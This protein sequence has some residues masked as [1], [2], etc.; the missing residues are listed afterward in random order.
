[1]NSSANGNEIRTYW[2]G[3]D[4]KGLF[5]GNFFGPSFWAVVESWGGCTPA[6]EGPTYGAGYEAWSDPAKPVTAKSSPLHTIFS[7][8]Y[9][10]EKNN[11]NAGIWPENCACPLDIQGK[12]YLENTMKASTKPSWACW[13]TSVAGAGVENAGLG[14]VRTKYFDPALNAPKIYFHDAAGGSVESIYKSNFSL[15][16]LFSLTKTIAYA[17][18]I[19]VPIVGPSLSNNLR[20]TWANTA[21]ILS[22]RSTG[23]VTKNNV[24]V[25]MNWRMD[26]HANNPIEASLYSFYR[27]SAKGEDGWESRATIES[28]AINTYFV[29]GN[30]PNSS[31]SQYCCNDFIAKWYQCGE[32]GVWNTTM[33]DKTVAFI[34]MNNSAPWINIK[35]EDNYRHYEEKLGCSLFKLK[36]NLKGTGAKLD[37]SYLKILKNEVKW[38]ISRENKVHI[39]VIDIMGKLIYSNDLAPEKD[40]TIFNAKNYPNR[41]LMIVVRDG[42][43]E[44]MYKLLN[45]E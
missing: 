32:G 16:F 20:Q 10:C 44:E 42:A 5:Q 45:N 39:E 33:R 18:L 17:P 24:L 21:P 34:N 15:E 9:V 25:D 13:R 4:G 37:Y 26:L 40:M 8:N 36:H 6:F 38:N 27:M 31:Q 3:T 43:H 14:L 1:V 7:F 41:L 35:T 2:D 29:E 11:K 30:I 12:M 23:V 28:R 19:L 22:A